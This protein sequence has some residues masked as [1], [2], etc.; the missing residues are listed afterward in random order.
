MIIE[1]IKSDLTSFELFQGFR[2]EAYSFFL[3]SGIDADSLGQYS[4]MGANPFLT[5]SSKDDEIDINDDG[6]IKK[7][8]GN[9]FDELNKLMAENNR[10]YESDFPFVGGAVGYFGYDLCHHT[11]RIPRTAVDD[12]KIPDCFM[13]FY[14]GIIIVDH[15]NDKTYLAA[16]GI[17]EKPENLI[18]DLKKGGP[19]TC[20]CKR[21]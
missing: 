3:D 19:G 16:L 1:E 12:V 21:R 10:D 18:A 8:K 15:Q 11:E 7:S 9:P 20:L 13:G 2:H 4:F 5:F 14:D 17:R 6:T